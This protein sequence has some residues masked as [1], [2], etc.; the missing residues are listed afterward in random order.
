MKLKL[1]EKDNNCSAHFNYSY[2]P[3]TC[4]LDVVTYNPTHKNH[5]LL[6]SLEGT[7]RIDALNNMY[8]YI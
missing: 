6:H 5:F 1:I 3:N 7:N 2:Q 8:E 4:V